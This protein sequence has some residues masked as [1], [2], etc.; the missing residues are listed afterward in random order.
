MLHPGQEVIGSGM[1]CGWERVKLGYF[2]RETTGMS[3]RE[4]LDLAAIMHARSYSHNPDLPLV[5]LGVIAILGM[6]IP[7][8]G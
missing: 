8:G 2:G 6:E 4:V 3:E 5:L 1:G 7:M